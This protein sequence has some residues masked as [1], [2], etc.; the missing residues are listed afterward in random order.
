MGVAMTKLRWEWLSLMIGF[1]LVSALFLPGSS[2]LLKELDLKLFSQLNG[3][4]NPSMA[5][6]V[7]FLNSKYGEWLAECSLVA[8]FYFSCKN[9]RSTLFSL[10]FISLFISLVQIVMGQILFGYL[11]DMKRYSPSLFTHVHVNI[12][13][14][15]PL[16]GNQIYQLGSL[17]PSFALTLSIGVCWIFRHAKRVFG[18]YA[19]IISFLFILPKLFAGFYGLSDL[20]FCLPAILFLIAPLFSYIPNYSS[21]EEVCQN[22]F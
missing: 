8:L 20:L 14:E 13:K 17:I 6:A 2:W 18:F 21:R 7:A 3:S 15:W 19:T 5:S 11:L 1:V 9:W 22:S 12:S 16:I 4:L 10:A